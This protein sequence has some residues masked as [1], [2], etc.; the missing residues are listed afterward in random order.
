MVHQPSGQVISERA[1]KEVPAAVSELL[2]PGWAKSELLPLNPA[3]EELQ[4]LKEALLLKLQVS[5]AAA[6]AG[7]VGVGWGGCGGV[8][9]LVVSLVMTPIAKSSGRCRGWGWGCH[10]APKL[11]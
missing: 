8:G 1:I 2:G 7:G 6:A 4:A 10:C 5:S 3:E 9:G 11:M